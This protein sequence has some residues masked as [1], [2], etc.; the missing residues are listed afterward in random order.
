V[1]V[2]ELFDLG[3]AIELLE[4][5]D[6]NRLRKR[7]G[8]LVAL[9][10]LELVHA[11][12]AHEASLTD[13]ADPRARLLDLAQHVRRQ[14]YRAPLVTRVHDHRVELL[15]VERVQAAGRLVEDEHSRAV[16]ESLDQ[17]HLPL[18]AGRVLPELA[19]RVE[20]EPIDE[21]LQV[22]PVDAPPKIGEVL[23]DLSAGQVRIQRR[24]AGDVA[25]APLDLYRLV[26]AVEA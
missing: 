11:A 23:D 20:V 2:V 24:F 18:V 21:P 15:L 1:T 8:D 13:D 25:D 6:G 22:C 5:L 19:A 16:H 7:D 14:E 12:D 9:D 26:P 10:V 4:G 17:H 3:H